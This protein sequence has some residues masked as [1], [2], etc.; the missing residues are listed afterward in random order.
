MAEREA[1]QHMNVER[2]RQRMRLSARAAG[3][4]VHLVD[5]FDALAIVGLAEFGQAHRARRTMKER[6][7]EMVFQLLD[8]RGHDR[9]RHAQLARRVG[10]TLRF[11]GPHKSLHRHEQVQSCLL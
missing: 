8:A 7:A 6:H 2:A 11:R 4:F 3:Q 1:R 5:Q 10:E 9:F